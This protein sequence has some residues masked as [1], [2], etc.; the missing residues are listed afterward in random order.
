MRRTTKKKGGV[1]AD[2]AI[3]P[4]DNSEHFAGLISSVVI[5]CALMPDDRNPPAGLKP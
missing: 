2:G 1:A 4:A 5:Y 3:G